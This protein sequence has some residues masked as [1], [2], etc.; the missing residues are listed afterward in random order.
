MERLVEL[1]DHFGLSLEHEH[2]GTPHGSDIQRLVT[3]VQNQ[4]LLHLSGNV[5]E[6]TV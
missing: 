4:N 5:A 1:L 2:V 3:R 6:R